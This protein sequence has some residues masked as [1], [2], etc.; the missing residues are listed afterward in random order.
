[1]ASSMLYSG[2]SSGLIMSATRNSPFRTTLM[3]EVAQIAFSP[4]SQNKS[5]IKAV[6]KKLAR[7][8]FSGLLDTKVIEDLFKVLRDRET[9]DSSDK[10]LRLQRQSGIAE[11]CTILE[12]HGQRRGERVQGSGDEP[13]KPAELW[14]PNQRDNPAWL[15]G[16]TETMSW[17]SL[18]PLNSC[19]I[20]GQL[21]LIRELHVDNRW[22]DFGKCWQ[23]CL[24]PIGT[25]FVVKDSCPRVSLGSVSHVA[26][27]SW[28]LREIHDED[29]SQKFYR[30]PDECPRE[31]PYHHVLDLRDHYVL[32]TEIVSPVHAGLLSTLAEVGSFVGWRLSGLPL[33]P[34]IHA[35]Q[36]CYWDMPKNELDR[37]AKH[38][39]AP[40][41]V[42]EFQL[43][44]G[45]LR[46]TFP[47]YSVEELGELLAL[48][49]ISAGEVTSDDLDASVVEDLVSKEDVEDVQEFL[50][51]QA[52]QR[53]ERQH[54]RQQAKAF[55][56]S[57]SDV[58]KDEVVQP[59]V[60]QPP[61][62][63]RRKRVLAAE[64]SA[65]GDID[66]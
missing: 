61:L 54:F 65:G 66:L 51:K 28:P 37:L 52:K 59:P 48:R 26:I 56:S 33:K 31:V 4:V 62:K 50:E 35:A 55:T 3:W 38:I 19:L 11:E 10:V 23:T 32:P 49:G 13:L 9:R 46:T 47:E 22:G 42:D 8:I 53:S 12:Q 1:M 18:K 41:S 20:P 7:T 15:E 24:F 34:E 5:Q 2:K 16:I 57:R 44:T 25:I 64:P 40:P 36:R 60:D 17:T 21:S 58:S 29:M 6:L 27:R 45:M 14:W 30:L 43:I 63:R 39:G